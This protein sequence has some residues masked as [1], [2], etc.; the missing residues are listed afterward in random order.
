MK[1][2][3]NLVVWIGLLLIYSCSSEPGTS[4]PEIDLRPDF[5]PHVD[6]YIE[7]ARERGRIVDFAS[8]GL[9]IK[10]REEEDEESIGVCFLG[11]YRIEINRPDWN[12]FSYNERER[13]IF[14]ELGHCEIGRGHKNN[15]LINDEWASIMRGVPFEED[16]MGPGVN[17]SGR[18]RLYY[19][20]ELFNPST[21][22]PEWVN[23]SQEY[24]FLDD[25]NR[26]VLYEISSDTTHFEHEFGLGS[27]SD[28]EIE[29]EMDNRDTDE[30]IAVIWG[31]NNNDN[32]FRIGYNKE[33]AFIV[34]SG[35]EIWGTLRFIEDFEFIIQNEYNKLTIRN[36]DNVYYI[37]VNEIFVYWFD[38]DG[39]SLGTVRSLERG[40]TN[41][42]RN[43]RISELSF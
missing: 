20:D 27:S 13:L 43:I 26:N 33:K 34:R 10:F 11:Q 16:V 22:A 30:F 39:H 2:L 17:Y 6:Q 9:S 1:T 31:E 4:S 24:E 36:I 40:E 28:F 35:Q 23:L 37:F 8:T 12:D 15:I 42:F 18:R 19:I 29:L 21:P 14:H 5:I 41:H 3:R 7:E 25:D 32:S 38:S